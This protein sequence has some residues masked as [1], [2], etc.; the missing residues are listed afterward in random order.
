MTQ[1]AELEGLAQRAAPVFRRAIG[2]CLAMLGAFV[3]PAFAADSAL[4]NVIGYSQDQRYFAF[5]EFGIQDGS[6]FA[7]SSIYLID[8]KEDRWVVGTP[9][10]VQADSEDQTLGEVRQATADKAAPR[11]DD[12]RIDV[13]AHEL[14][15]IPDGTPGADGSK[16]T[17]GLPGF[18]GPGSTRGEF[19]LTL[20]MFEA[21]SGAPC[22]EWFDS[23]A[24][25]YAAVMSD[26]GVTREVHRDSTLPRSRGCPADYRVRAIY[27]PFMASDISRSVAIVSVYSRGFEGLDRRFMALPL[28]YPK[29]GF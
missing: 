18:S 13:P 20:T 7:Y 22:R 8:L 5:E 2:F 19:T 27:A 29:G 14:A 11:L 26:L 16:L 4:V 10:R 9:I 23:A 6:G 17:F 15:A 12:L 24:I 28:A 25:G 3:S 1:I 21:I